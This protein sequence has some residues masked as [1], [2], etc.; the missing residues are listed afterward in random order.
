MFES[1]DAEA[2]DRVGTAAGFEFRVRA[3][4]FILVGHEIHHRRVL[5]E[6]YLP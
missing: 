3:F 5:A 4:P 2:W 6:K 1:F